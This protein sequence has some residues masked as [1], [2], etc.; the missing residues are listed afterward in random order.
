MIAK[1]IEMKKLNKSN[2]SRLAT[3]ITN[4]QGK[5]ERVGIVRITNCQSEAAI[6]AACE[7]E[8]V[9]SK[10]KRTKIDKTYHL[11]VS[12]REGERP[13][14]DVLHQIENRLV[15][16]IGL[17]DHQR[18]SAIHYDTDHVH[19][20]VAINKIHP[21]KF[22]AIEP[23]F[24]KRKLGV[25]C[26]K[27]EIEFNLQHD[28]HTPK[29][30]QA[31][32]RAM[33]MEMAG[34]IESL[35]GWV[36]RGCLPELLAAQ[37]WKELHA[38]LEQN[39]L[40][41]LPQNNGFIITN[42]KGH[43]AKASSFDRQ[44]SKHVLEKKL[45]PY[46]AITEGKSQSG[47]QSGG[48]KI[49]PVQS[50]VDTTA[51]WALYQQERAAHRQKQFVGSK[52]A[53]ARRDRLI[54]AAKRSAKLKRMGIRLMQGKLAKK[55]M[56][57]AVSKKLLADI[58]KINQA[59]AKVH[60]PSAANSNRM[61]WHD[62]LKAKAQAGNME[63][64]A[65]LRARYERETKYGNAITHIKPG[66]DNRPLSSGKIDAVTKKGTIHYKIADGIVRDDGKQLRMADN[67]S[68]EALK[69]VLQ[70]AV[71]RFGPQLNI[72]GSEKFQNAIAKVAAGAPISISLTKMD[73]QQINNQTG[74]KA[75][76]KTD[77]ANSGFATNKTR[78]EQPGTINASSQSWKDA[79]VYITERNTKRQK[80]FD[81]LNHRRYNK[82]T[83]AGAYAYSG[84]R[85]IEGAKLMLLKSASEILVMPV[86]EKMAYRVWNLKT[87]SE[88]KISP[89][90]II[91]TRAQSQNRGRV[92][93]RG[94]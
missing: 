70:L 71:K 56:Y 63:A 25:E 47:S 23:Y 42:G 7:I 94:R 52:E 20:H 19:M 61:V 3:Y 27:L 85:Q 15:K 35:I 93:S 6:W 30:T 8:G 41:L 29:R 88:I 48:Y 60:L 4:D 59:Y 21:T 89:D 33:D 49:K 13:S 84:I 73:N 53:L 82:E 86:D 43:A 91:H 76:M 51:L 45:G 39:R 9:Q 28:N 79:D 37:S 78:A 74:M 36:K 67:L 66:N 77:Q 40:K 14:V 26:E 58:K 62:W 2:F 72:Q 65:V 18:I 5:N 16:A 24:D 80:G 92:L 75:D 32:A 90:G 46:R 38:V 22:T 81:V 34:G 1:R 44:L 31:E 17:G 11:L 64:V 87:G 83:D 50:K 12:F 69:A 68:D 55:I 10:N 57:H 54:A